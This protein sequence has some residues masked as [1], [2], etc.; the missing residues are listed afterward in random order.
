MKILILTLFFIFFSQQTFSKE[1]IYCVEINFP[2]AS[3]YTANSQILEKGKNNCKESGLYRYGEYRATKNIRIEKSFFDKFILKNAPSHAGEVSIIAHKDLQKYFDEKNISINLEKHKTQI[4]DNIKK[5]DD[6]RRIAYE[7]EN[8]SCH[9]L[10]DFTW[11]MDPGFVQLERNAVFTFKSKTE[12][13]IVIENISLT[14]AEH[15]LIR[16]KDYN[17]TLKPFEVLVLYLSL[18][19][20][21]I[22][23]IKKGGANCKFG[24]GKENKNDSNT[25]STGTK[26]LLKKII[27]K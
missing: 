19:D 14:T 18:K 5:K 7:K 27:G 2:N 3:L 20:L 26:N 1:K 17:V 22:D 6:E 4:V 24:I 10:Y 15:K 16:I 11:T 21:N 23:L 8:V 25:D 9:K 12:K 13:S